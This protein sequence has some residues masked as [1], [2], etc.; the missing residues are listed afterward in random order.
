MTLHD[1]EELDNHLRRGAD[2]NLALAATLSVDEVVEAVVLKRIV[3][4]RPSKDDLDILTR[5]ETRTILKSA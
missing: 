5:T 2:Q 3:N 1:A 4:D